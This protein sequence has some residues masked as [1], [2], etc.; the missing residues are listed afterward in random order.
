MKM[1][2][3]GVK[4]IVSHIKGEPVEKRIDTGVQLV[5][6]DKMND[7]AVKELLHPDLSR[8]LKP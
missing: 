8:W 2:Y 5:T 1:G 4:T 7:P 6:R 3:L